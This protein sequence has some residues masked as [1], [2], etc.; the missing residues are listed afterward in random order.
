MKFCASISSNDIISEH[1]EKLAPRKNIKKE[2][3]DGVEM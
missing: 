1:I 2:L 3:S